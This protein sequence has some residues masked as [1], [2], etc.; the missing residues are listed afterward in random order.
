MSNRNV[1]LFLIALLLLSACSVRKYLPAG[2]TLY[3]GTT[4]TINTEKGVTTSKHTL[5]KELQVAAKPTPNKFLFGQPYK[6]WWWYKIGEPKKEKGFKSWIRN[7]LGEPPVLSSR[8]NAP[9]TAEDMQ[10]LL[11]NGGYF[12]STVK[13]DTTIKGYFTTTHYTADVFP[14]YKIK[15]ITWVSDSSKLLNMLDSLSKTKKGLLKPGAAYSLDVIQSERSRLD[16]KLKTKGYYFFN[17]DYLMVYADSTI[18]NHQVNL[19]LN[20]K[21]S[22]PEN[23]KHVYTID[24]IIVF[25]NYTL[26]FPP[27]DTSK[28]GLLNYDGILI[29]DTVHKYRP[30]LFSKAITY[31][32]GDIYSSK[33]QNTS[34]NRLINMGTFKFVKNQFNVVTDSGDKY[35]LNAYYYITP[36]K[37]KSLQ[38]EIDG[39]TEESR[40]LGSQLSVNWKNRNTFGG[41]ELLSIRAYGGVELSFV[42]SLHGDNNYTLGTDVSLTFPKYVIPFF[43]I[44]ENNLF[45]PRTNFLAGYELLIKQQFYTQNIFRFQYGY[46]W[47]ESANKEHT[48]VPFAVTFLNASHITDSFYSAALTNPSILLNVYSETI[49]GSYYTYTVTNSNPKKRDQFNFNAGVDLSGNIA[50]LITDAKQPRQKEIFGTPFAQYVKFDADLRYT[51]LLGEKSSI[52]NHLQI[53]I[54]MPY[55]NSSQLPFTKQYIIGGA[56]SIRGFPVYSLGPGSYLPTANDIKYFQT[57]GGDYKLLFNTELR[58]PIVGHLAGAVFFDAGNIWTKDTLLFGPKAQ[59]TKTFYKDIAVAAGFGIRYDL[60]VLLLRL[61]LGIPLRKPYLPDGQ[62]WVIDQIAFGDK[63]WRAEN[64]VFNLA[65]G[66]PF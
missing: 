6:V 62:R 43:K 63:D 52:A 26:L 49:L 11:E 32:P 44:K 19:F 38:A 10:S 27:P 46:T 50:G 5:K 39:F 9:V 13:G 51:H 61:D 18:G 31:R 28:R 14:Q 48:L 30:D 64:L 23:A 8:V 15:N 25:P 42:D 45:P 66:Y 24:N 2:E 1:Y 56:N 60:G 20:L 16:L 4:V 54:G 55:D 12:H 7:K 35:R 59:L 58:F 3:K 47:K 29:R 41:A 40:Y 21:K 53:G 36:S 34:L 17:P 37:N 65:I 33:D 57:I 22:T